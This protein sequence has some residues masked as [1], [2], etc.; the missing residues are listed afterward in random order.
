MKTSTALILTASILSSQAARAERVDN[1]VLLD[2]RGAGHELYYL[3]DH[4]AVVIMIQGNGCPIARNAWQA[5]RELRGAYAERGIAF[6]MLNSNLQDDRA[7]ILAEAREF[8]FDIPILVDESQLV[9]EALGV[10]RTAEVFVI[11]TDRWELV[12][13][14]PIDDRLTYERQRAEATERYLADALDAVLAD[15]PVEVAERDALGCLVNFP[16]RAS[17]TASTSAYRETVA[18][19]LIEHCVD[20]HRAGGIAPWAMTS[21]RM[22]LGFAPMIRE[23]VRTKRMPPWHADPHVGAWIGDRNLS[24]KD[25]AALVGWIEAGAPRGEGADPLEALAPPASEWPLGEPDLVLTLPPF[26]IPATGVVDYQYPLVENPLAEPVWVKAATIAPGERTVVHHVLAGYVS[27]DG[28]RGAG[29]GN[30]FENYLNGYAPGVE[31]HEFPED[32]GVLVE[33]GGGFAFQMHY[34]PTGKAETDVTRLGLYFHDQPPTYVLRHNVALN[35]RIRIEPHAAAHEESA[36]LPFDKDAIVYSLLPHAHYRGKSSKFEIEYP[37]G[38]IELLLSVPRYDFNWQR[39]YAFAEPLAVPAGSKIV[40]TTVYDNSAQN[41]GNPDPSRRVPWGQQSW[42][43]MLYGAIRY[44]WRDETADAPI[45]DAALARTQQ[46]FG[47]TDNDRNGLLEPAE[48][49]LGL[50]RALEPRFE[51]MDL[52]GDGALSIAEL[53][54]TLDAIRD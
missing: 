40:H 9:G 5:L 34:T 17:E 25:A 38:R 22:I 33:P 54:Q 43:E 24:A 15:R 16:N 1:F 14:G 47:Y 48:L 6:L 2:Q 44:R 12:Y 35:P 10:I 18:P 21:H 30:V 8:D 50:R 32:T 41:P 51:S 49:P 11:D 3:S 23:V 31:T 45:H 36:Y 46:F 13:R 42:D 29:D 52:D 7:S 53:G 37:D 26:E 27:A 39:E 4:E 20:C 28:R 19:I